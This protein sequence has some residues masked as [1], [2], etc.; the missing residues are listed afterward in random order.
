MLKNFKL[1]TSVILVTASSFGA[2]AQT[3][4]YKD[5]ILDGKPARLNV[6]TGEVLLVSGEKATV[7]KVKTIT[8]KDVVKTPKKTVDNTINSSKSE[9]ESNL[10]TKASN[11]E[12][13]DKAKAEMTADK[14]KSI[15]NSDTVLTSSKNQKETVSQIESKNKVA[16]TREKATVMV[17]DVSSPSVSEDSNTNF[18][19]VVKGETLYSLSKRYNTT[20]GA[21]K[22]ANNLETTLIKVG[23]N[24]RVR[25]FDSSSFVQGSD[26]WTVSK[27]DTLYS[28]AKRN[29]TTVDSIKSLN[30]LVSNLIKIGQKLQ[31]K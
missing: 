14:T 15:V 13:F 23:Q 5:V 16:A 27:G 4:T 10:I 29:N 19:K 11:K 24:L 9:I 25:N 2:V 12:K 30:G 21:L 31:L 22:E 8:T 26:V 7:K 18:H 17:Y 3:E 6:K 20:L 1:I 28:I